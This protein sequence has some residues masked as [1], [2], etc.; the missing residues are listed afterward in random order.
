MPAVDSASRSRRAVAT[1]T[2]SSLASSAAVT[3][4]R[5]C[6]SKSAATRRSARMA[7][8]SLT[9][10]S[11]DEHFSAENRNCH[12]QNRRKEEPMLR[13]LSTVSFFADDVMAAQAWYAELLGIEPY[14]VRPA[15]G[16]FAYVEY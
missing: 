12:L 2:S 9:K 8:A 4:P 15:R 11:V 7:P 1:D 16:T 3:R 5:A 14:F 6:M 13:G 10:C